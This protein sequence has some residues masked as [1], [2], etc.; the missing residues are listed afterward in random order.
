MAGAYGLGGSFT[1]GRSV[2]NR[3]PQPVQPEAYPM[4]D[5]TGTVAPNQGANY[6]PQMATASGAPV[7]D[8]G[9]AGGLVKGLS[10]TS[11][12][13]NDASGRAS[14]Q[15]ATGQIADNGGVVAGR[16]PQMNAVE[17][18]QAQGPSLAEIQAEMQRRQVGAQLNANPNN[19]ALAG[20]MMAK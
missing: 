18:A 10:G 11:R 13:T 12:I 14:Q 8:P 19:S 17:Q 3:K 20:Y 4:P 15:A 7:T 6:A 16:M 1:Q 2:M 9:M 5:K